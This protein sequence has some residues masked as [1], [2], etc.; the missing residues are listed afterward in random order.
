MG[1]N[2]AQFISNNKLKILHE[3]L[4]TLNY[5]PIFVLWVIYIKQITII[6]IK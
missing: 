3:F 2:E 5:I 1:L 6:L 4:E